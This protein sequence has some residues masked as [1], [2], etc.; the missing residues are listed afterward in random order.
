MQKKKIRFQ[1]FIS[2]EVVMN[3]KI[4]FRSPEI[5]FKNKRYHAGKSALCI[6]RMNDKRVIA[7]GLSLEI[8][9]L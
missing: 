4:V 6:L 3:V 8:T 1:Y 2:T 7:I 9:K 5:G